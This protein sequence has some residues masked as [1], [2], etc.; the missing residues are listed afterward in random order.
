MIKRLLRLL[1]ICFVIGNVLLGCKPTPAPTATLQPQSNRF[2]GLTVNLLTFDGPQI[3]EPL[4]RR[5]PE[6][7]ALTGAK[8]NIVTV[9]FADLYSKILSTKTN[10][11]QVFVIQ[12]QWTVDYII[13]GYLE[14]L[15]P[16]VK[17]DQA[18]AWDDIAPFFRDISA[19]YQGNIYTIPLDGDFQMVY[20]RT[21][22]LEQAKLKPPQTWTEYLEIAKTFH[23]KDFNGDGQADYGSCISKKHKAQAYWMVWSIASAFLQSQGTRQGAFFDTETMAPLIN[24]EAFATA[25]DIYKQTTAYGPPDELKLDVGD[26]RNLF[27]AG[28]CALSVDW[29]DIGTLAIAPTSKVIDKVGATVLPG[30][31]QVLDRKTG[32]LVTCDK[33]TCPYAINGINYAPYAAF[34]GW[35]G[36]IKANADPKVKDA[37]YAFLSYMSQPAQANVDVTIGATGFNPYRVSQ[38]K[39]RALWVKAGMSQEAADLYIGAIG[40]SL[41]SP[42]MVLDLRIPHNNDYQQTVLDNTIAQF[43]ADQITKEQAIKQIDEGWNKVTTEFGR[44]AQLKAY[45]ASLG[46]E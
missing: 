26:T 21:D 43:L 24:N 34:G 11:F 29:G 44:E 32:K 22:L 8:I 3:V 23:G 38:F 30:S 27:T 17:A 40:V 15:S 14:N 19:I 18:L 46:K 39:D 10:D 28:R 35:S 31:T 6:F 16:R 41:S 13:P 20:Y 25:L 2:D 36:I 45:R 9:P 12:P 7:D 1:T 33:L 37:A 42:N 5:A 4:K